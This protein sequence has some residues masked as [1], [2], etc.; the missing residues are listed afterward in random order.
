M[1][2]HLGNGCTFHVVMSQEY[3][4]R[5]PCRTGG[6]IETAGVLVSY[7]Y[8]NELGR[9]FGEKGLKGFLMTIFSLTRTS[10]IHN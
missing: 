7:L 9:G 1:M 2:D 6:K 10:E 4:F 8:L 5:R 3:R